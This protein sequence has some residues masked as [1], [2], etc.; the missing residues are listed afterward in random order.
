MKIIPFIAILLFIGTHLLAQNLVPNGSFEDLRDLPIKPN[1]KN[2]FE[3]EPLSGYQPFQRNL[4]FWFAGTNTTPD[5]RIKSNKHFGIC[6]KRYDD[7]DEPKTGNNSVGIIT[8]MINSKTETY[9]EYLQVKLKSSLKKGI[10]TYIELWICKERQAKLVSNN[11][12]CYF[13]ENKIN[14]GKEEVI[15]VEPQFNHDAIMNEQENRWIKIIGE[16]TPEKELNFLTVGNFFKNDKTQAKAYDNYT[17]S[18]YTPP[19]AYYLIDDIRVWQEGINTK[20]EI[21]KFEEK[22]ISINESIVLKN[23][24]FDHDSWHLREDSRNGLQQLLAFLNKNSSV[25]IL[26]TGHTDNN[27][28]PT[29][30]QKLSENRSKAV[31][32]YL[33][34]N[35]ISPKRLSY[36]GFGERKPLVENS[37]EENRQQNRRVEFMILENDEL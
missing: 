18:A 31:M 13:S 36:Q 29:W 6:R 2:S 21:V 37:N 14:A 33:I 8:Y 20:E 19:Y 7:C 35:E 22:E 32:E 25:E 26:I 23:V 28:N 9:R 15:L 5:L 4:N 30:N 3:Y 11:V 1:P 34:S 16:F 24:E 12:G 17:G 10:K 27:G